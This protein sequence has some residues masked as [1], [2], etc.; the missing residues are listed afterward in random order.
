LASYCRPAGAETITG[1][2]KLPRWGFIVWTFA[3]FGEEIAYRGYLL[4]VQPKSAGRR[5]QLIGLI[6]LISVLFGYGHYYKG[7]PAFWTLELRIG[8]GGGLYVSGPKLWASILLMVYRYVCSYCA[9]LRMG[10]VISG[11]NLDF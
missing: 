8:S 10:I 5:R 1:N 7:P 2:I 9:L 6:V 4:T 3:A 11:E